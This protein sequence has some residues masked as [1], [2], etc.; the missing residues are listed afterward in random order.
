[1]RYV[2]MMLVAVACSG[3]VACTS[4]TGAEIGQQALAA[5]S[6]FQ[7]SMNGGGAYLYSGDMNGG[8]S[9][10][11]WESGTGKSASANLFYSIQQVDPTSEVCFTETFPGKDPGMP[12]IEYTY[13]YY[14]R[15]I[16][17]SGYG[18]I[19]A[20]DL[21]VRP[22]AVRLETT[23]APGPVFFSSR[24]TYDMMS[25]DPPVCTDGSGGALSVTWH[26]D[27]VSSM[28]IAGSQQQQWGPFS[29]KTGGIFKAASA[30]AD[31]TVLGQS[32]SGAPGEIRSSAGASVT[33][34]LAMVPPLSPPPP[35]I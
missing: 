27:G 17:E 15:Y 3:L 35:P 11:V 26:K 22:G 31:G 29:M 23:V 5:K 10:D 14:T 1:M 16:Y 24:C 9:L 6:V 21:Q 34:G 18:E 32:V 13:C 20:K 4:E 12:P 25:M 33:K 30:L 7:S 2:K 19:P 8:I 28:K